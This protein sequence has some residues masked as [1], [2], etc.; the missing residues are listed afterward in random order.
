MQTWAYYKWINEKNA[1][2]ATGKEVIQKLHGN[3]N[4]FFTRREVYS[5]KAAKREL[6]LQMYS[7]N[8]AT[9][10]VPNGFKKKEGQ[11]SSQEW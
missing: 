3:G 2:E 10:F 8:A 11:I 5:H 9:E 4:I 1:K 7:S 6:F